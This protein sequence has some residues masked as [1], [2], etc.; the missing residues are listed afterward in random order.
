MF[1]TLPLPI[2]ITLLNIKFTTYVFLYNTQEAIYKVNIVYYISLRVQFH[3]ITRKIS[4]I[5]MGEHKL[6][7]S[8]KSREPQI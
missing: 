4:F 6:N 3:Q 7:V 8:E 1:R 2:F 5:K